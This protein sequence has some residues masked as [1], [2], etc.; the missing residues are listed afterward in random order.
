MTFS[1]FDIVSVICFIV[2]AIT[3]IWGFTTTIR[4]CKSED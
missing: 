1:F 3:A 2:L 4:P